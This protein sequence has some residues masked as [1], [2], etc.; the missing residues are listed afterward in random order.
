MRER[1]LATGAGEDSF[2]GMMAGRI[3]IELRIED[4]LKSIAVPIRKA[5]SAMVF[6]LIGSM[7][8]H[9]IL[10]ATAVVSG[11]APPK[12]PQQEISVEI[13]QDV[14]KP[15][16]PAPKP[17][18]APKT[19]QAK[20]EQ[21]APAPVKPPPVAKAE[22]PK[23][24][25]AKPELTKPEPTKPDPVKPEPP[26][27]SAAK[28]EPPP[29]KS[30]AA[31][32]EPPK[33]PVAPQA[34]PEAPPAKSAA[35]AKEIEDLQ[36][37]L[38]ELRAQQTDLNNQLKT[39]SAAD[40]DPGSPDPAANPLASSLRAIAM[41]SIG[42]STGDVV[43]YQQLVFSQLAKA[44]GDGEYNGPAGTTGVRF[45][46]DDAGQLLHA[47]VASSSGNPTLDRQALDIVHRAAP[48]PPPPKGSDHGFSAYVHFVPSK[49]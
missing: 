39:A 40:Q 14:P 43:G 31:K 4:S 5:S 34:K 20:R 25:P 6:V 32:V 42:D 21:A 49:T 48:F 15:K 28:P 36:K 7:V 16:A 2:V 9:A 37:Q 3:P 22:P 33:P 13:V 46:V 12:A 17:Q 8:V 45:E 26:K 1:L 35:D 11:W 24:A 29:Q 10:L 44:K 19:Q 30:A 18:T 47:E 41:P 27:Q 38:A 23:P